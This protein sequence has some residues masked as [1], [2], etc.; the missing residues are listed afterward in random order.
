MN[1]IKSV[2]KNMSAAQRAE[3]K[4]S[5]EFI[6]NCEYRGTHIKVELEAQ[7]GRS[8]DSDGCST[9]DS[10]GYYYCDDCDD[11]QVTCLEC[12]GD[13]EADT[14]DENDCEFC[15]ALAAAK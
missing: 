15:D 8:Y 2:V 4:K 11:G 13:W 14:P 10:D 7:L 5:I 6:K 12:D 3:L 1:A 9:C